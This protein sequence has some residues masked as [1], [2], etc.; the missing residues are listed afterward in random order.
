MTTVFTLCSSNYLAQAKAL[1]DSLLKH[2]PDYRFVIGLVDRLSDQVKPSYWEPHELIPVE[3]ITIEGFDA[4]ADDY[5]VVELNTAVKPFYI[6]HLYRRD[7]GVSEVIYLDP[8]ILVF[9]S[10]KRIEETLKQYSIVL[11]PHICNFDDSLANV[12]HEI[13]ALTM[14]LYN[15]GFIGTSRTETTFGFLD[16]WQKRLRYCCHYR[17]GSGVFVDQ[18][19][20]NLAPLYFDGVYVEKDP[21]YNVCYWNRFERHLTQQNGRYLVNGNHDLVFYHFSAY[22]PDNPENVAGRGKMTAISMRECPDLEPIYNDY[23]NRLI[24][25]NYSSIRCLP[26]LLRRKRRTSKVSFKRVLRPMLSW[27]FEASPR[28]VQ[29]Y[30]RLRRSARSLRL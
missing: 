2:N 9:G 27:L 25:N 13:G 16:W 17:P 3:D 21:G 8:D 15:L 20:V 18:L 26:Y 23:R 22:N 6:E 11:T 29:K 14:G 5:N 12:G 1:G 19:W 24:E 30:V 7:P 4:M 28:A 10:F